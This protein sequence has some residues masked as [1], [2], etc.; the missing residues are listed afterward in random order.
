MIERDNLLYGLIIACPL[1]NCDQSCPIEKIRDLPVRER[2]SHLSKL[3]KEERISLI[4]KHRM[5]I[6]E[7]EKKYFQIE[8]RTK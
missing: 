8:E 1:H 5:C 7:F 6:N 4:T 2:V 3:N